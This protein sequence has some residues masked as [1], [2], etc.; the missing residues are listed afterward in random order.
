MVSL[1]DRKYTI[2]NPF[3][4]IIFHYRTLLLINM[5]TT[6]LQWIDPFPV[7]KSTEIS[8]FESTNPDN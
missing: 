2:I 4:R 3:K 7:K 6:I 8:D 5:Y 1:N